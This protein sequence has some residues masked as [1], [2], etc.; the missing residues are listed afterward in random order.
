M[1]DIHDLVE[2]IPRAVRPVAVSPESLRRTRLGRDVHGLGCRVAHQPTPSEAVHVAVSLERLIMS[3]RLQPVHAAA[4][5]GK[6]FRSEPRGVRL[7]ALLSSPARAE[8]RG[9][10]KVW[11]VRVGRGGA[12][13]RVRG[14]AR[15]GCVGARVLIHPGLR[16]GLFAAPV[17]KGQQAHE[18]S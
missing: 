14:I 16:K 18:P 7:L 5:G 13:G 17:G 6:I 1:V 2:G 12:G 9:G 3:R 10:P 15:A 4:E 11:I 8:E